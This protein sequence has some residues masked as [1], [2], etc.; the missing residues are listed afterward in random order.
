MLLLYTL[1]YFYTLYATSINSMLLLYTLCYFSLQTTL[2]DI[3]NVYCYTSS[4]PSHYTQ[5]HTNCCWQ[6]KLSL[7]EHNGQMFSSTG[8]MMFYYSLHVIFLSTSRYL[9]SIKLLQMIAMHWYIT[10]IIYKFSWKRYFPLEKEKCFVQFK[11]TQD[12]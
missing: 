10:V 11:T 5:C 9:K 8:T 6:R 1:C 4:V 2:N 7:N 3:Q 12:S